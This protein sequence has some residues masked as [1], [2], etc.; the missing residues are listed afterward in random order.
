MRYLSI[1][2]F[3]LAVLYTIGYTQPGYAIDPDKQW[4][5][6]CQNSAEK[7]IRN[8]EKGVNKFKILE[9][10]LEKTKSTDTKKVLEGSGK[11][12]NYDDQWKD[13]TF[14]C[15]YDKEANEVAKVSYDVK[16]YSSGYNDGQYTKKGECKLWDDKQDYLDMEGNCRVVRKKSDNGKEYIVTYNNGKE[17]RF[18]QQGSTYKVKMPKEWASNPGYVS[19]QGNKITF[20]WAKWKLV[21]KEY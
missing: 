18:I 9:N 5:V 4:V 13:F 12:S 11:F 16:G 6:E 2:F 21:F 3:T 1:L 17:F 14:K 10:S 19:D 15:V 7:R 20:E 8:Y